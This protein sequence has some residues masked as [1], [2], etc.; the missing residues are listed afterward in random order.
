MFITNAD[1][2]GTPRRLAIP[3]L[4]G[5][6]ARPEWSPNGTQLAFGAGSDDGWT[7]IYVVDVSPEG[8][9]SRPRRLRVENLLEATEPS[10]SPDGTEIAFSG[11]HSGYHAPGKGYHAIFRIDVNSL[12]QTRLTKGSDTE[13]S[14]TWSPDGENIA[15]VRDAT[16][17]SSIYVVS[18]DGSSPTLVRKFPFGI[19]SPDW[20]PLP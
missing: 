17:T 1:G 10:W 16:N 12:E 5:C 6:I 20:R 8:A 2:S 14:P 4:S 19:L 18:S 15:Y 3:G 7:D 13:Y 11:V 9:M